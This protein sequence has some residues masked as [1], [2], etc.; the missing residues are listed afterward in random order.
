MFSFTSQFFCVSFIFYDNTFCRLFFFLQTSQN[1]TSGNSNCGC[2]K[3]FRKLGHR[4]ECIDV[5]ECL[6]SPCEPNLNCI[7]TPGGY[8]CVCSNGQIY[9]PNSQGCNGRTLASQVTNQINKGMF[10]LDIRY[11]VSTSIV[12]TICLHY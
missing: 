3:G 8:Q 11:Y 1:G 4:G 6:D 5:N 10:L 2:P 12:N 7:N 9:E